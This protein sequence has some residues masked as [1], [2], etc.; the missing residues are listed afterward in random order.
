MCC[1]SPNL[2]KPS[3]SISR[4]RTA[5]SNSSLFNLCFNKFAAALISSFETTP[6]ASSSITLT[7][8]FIKV[9]YSSASCSIACNR[10]S[11]RC[12]TFDEGGSAASRS[13]V[14]FLE[15]FSSSLCCC[16]ALTI[17]GSGLISAFSLISANFSKVAS[18][19]NEARCCS[20]CSRAS[21]LACSACSFNSFNDS[22][23]SDNNEDCPAANATASANDSTRSICFSSDS[24]RAIS[25]SV[26]S[27]AC[28]SSRIR[29]I[30]SSAMCSAS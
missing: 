22:R 17:N 20:N 9:S 14:S 29:S 19:A 24:S 25:R 8:C 12:C 1:I 21:A 15:T 2:T 23:S 6:S 3:P 11:K 4:A 18:S 10:L 7:I 30:S 16:F 27:S 5:A 26:S 28:S 13:S